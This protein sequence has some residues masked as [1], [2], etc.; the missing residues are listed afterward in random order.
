MRDAQAPCDSSR[1]TPKPKKKPERPYNRTLRLVYP[2]T[3]GQILLRTDLDWD[4][5]IPATRR[6]DD[7]TWEFDLSADRSWLHYKPTLVDG[8]GH[9]HWAP[10]MNEVV[11]LSRTMPYVVY[12]HFLGDDTGHITDVFTTPSELL[13][14][15]VPIRVYLPAGY[16]ENTLKR[17]SVLYMQD[18]AN[19]FLPD[20][21]FLGQDWSMRQTLETLDGMSLIHQTLIVAVHTEDRMVDYT[22][23]GFD[24]YARAL[25]TEIKPAIDARF[26]TLTGRCD[27]SLMGSSLGGVASF[28]C[29]WQY[30]DIFGNAACLSSTFGFQDDL[31]DRVRHDELGVRQQLK[32]YLDSGWPRDNYEST[33]AM[34]AALLE[35]GFILGQNLHHVAFPGDGHSESFWGERAHLPIQLFAGRLRRHFGSEAETRGC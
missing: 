18:G 28:A 5:S 26:R 35:R 6:V 34:S 11:T 33:L 25:A 13:G 20:E 17:Y 1:V 12:P 3:D 10:G 9:V 31:M 21:A 22:K 7:N 14:R 16:D 32:I 19:A 29:A 23:P 27:T 8:N 30:P 4:R 2:S 15:E 24:T